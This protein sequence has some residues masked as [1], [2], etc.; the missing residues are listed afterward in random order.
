MRR[1]HLA[2][3]VPPDDVEAGR[4]A[5]VHK[6]VRA[7]SGSRVRVREE[8]R[9]EEDDDVREVEAAEGGHRARA[10][11]DEEARQLPQ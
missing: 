4:C 1:G 6:E 7:W 8:V 10:Q 5:R 3:G 9:A 11:H 2:A